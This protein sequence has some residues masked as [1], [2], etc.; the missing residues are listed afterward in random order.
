MII[1]SET[2]AE[3]P[4]S[5]TPEEEMINQW[6][7]RAWNY[8]AENDWLDS[9]SLL[10]SSERPAT[11]TTLF[12]DNEKIAHYN[13]EYRNKPTP[14]NVLS[15]PAAL[16]PIEIFEQTD[17]PLFLGDIIIAPDIIEAEAKAQ[18]KEIAHHMTHMFL[19]ALL[20][21][22]GFD[23]IEEEEAEEMEQLERELLSLFSISDPYA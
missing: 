19:H 7:N 17:L 20:H 14:T 21:L 13:G 23:H 16:P 10:A 12:V 6:L 18:Q 9:L 2:I 8:L 4:H 5:A 11:I 1:K 22:L 15:F 3:Y